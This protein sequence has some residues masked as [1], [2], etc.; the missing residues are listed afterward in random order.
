MMFV[1]YANNRESDSVKMWN[2]ETNRV[3]T[4]RDV[5]W[6]KRMFYERSATDETLDLEPDALEPTADDAIDDKAV[7]DDV[8]QSI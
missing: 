1:G 4:T 2:P 3:V 5:I 7:A 8:E 6:L